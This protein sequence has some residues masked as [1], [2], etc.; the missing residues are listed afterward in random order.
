MLCSCTRSDPVHNKSDPVILWKA[1]VDYL[2]E[3]AM[4]ITPE[5]IQVEQP[6]ADDDE[7]ET[8]TVNQAH[9]HGDGEELMENVSQRVSRPL[10]L[11]LEKKSLF[12]LIPSSQLRRNILCIYYN[13]SG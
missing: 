11:V 6:Q 13:G 7:K 9:K 8:G 12:L 2:D 5:M 1:A 10:T 3:W 4:E